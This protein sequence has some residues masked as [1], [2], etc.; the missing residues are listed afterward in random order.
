[1]LTFLRLVNVVLLVSIVACI[2][3]V[4]TGLIVFV[5]F[6]AGAW[7]LNTFALVG[8]E[9]RARASRIERHP[10]NG[11]DVLPIPAVVHVEPSRR[12]A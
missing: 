11:R 10:S 4:L 8:Y 3:A 2:L 5:P 6:L 9:E 7:V 1:M 12:N